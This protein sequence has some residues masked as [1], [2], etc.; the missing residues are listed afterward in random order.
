MGLEQVIHEYL[1]A[2]YQ[3]LRV[4][5]NDFSI[6]QDEETG[7]CTAACSGGHGS[8]VEVKENIDDESFGGW[9]DSINDTSKEEF[10]EA[11]MK[12]FATDILNDV[13]LIVPQGFTTEKFDQ[14]TKERKVK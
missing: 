1:G 8:L 5:L 14:I 10:I 9:G 2:V 4:G 12:M 11:C 6:Y 3:G 13:C 7:E